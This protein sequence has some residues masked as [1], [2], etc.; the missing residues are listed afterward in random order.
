MRR[1]KWGDANAVQGRTAK[2]KPHLCPFGK[3]LFARSLRTRGPLCASQLWKAAAA[4]WFPVVGNPR[5]ASVFMD[6]GPPVCPGRAKRL[7]LPPVPRDAFPDWG[8]CKEEAKGPSAMF[9]RR[10]PI[11]QSRRGEF[12]S[13]LSARQAIQNP[14]KG[15]FA[16]GVSKCPPLSGIQTRIQFSNHSEIQ[17]STI[18]T[19]RDEGNQHRIP[20]IP[21]EKPGSRAY[22]QR[23]GGSWG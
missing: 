11:R 7:K 8:D 12:A 1:R 2:T 21:D 19:I 13:R 6:A 10:T 15:E 17:L 22:D 14:P 16:R 4:D 23:L 18:R 3:L 9:P 5:R 20:A